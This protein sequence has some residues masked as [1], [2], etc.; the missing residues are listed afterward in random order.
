MDAVDC[1][2]WIVVCGVVVCG[3]WCGEGDGVAVRRSGDA[4]FQPDRLA[5]V[6]SRYSQVCSASASDSRA[7]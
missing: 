7:H 2:L 6:P 3:A 1:G 4:K 5:E